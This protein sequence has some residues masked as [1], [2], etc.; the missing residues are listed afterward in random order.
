L[1]FFV[2]TSFGLYWQNENQRHLEKEHLYYLS[3][4]AQSESTAIERRV[5]S[6]FAATNFLAFE[7]KQNNGDFFDFESYAKEVINSIGGIS[8][9]Q[10]A[11]DGIVSKVYPI[12][13]NEVVIGH[14]LFVDDKRTKEAH[15]ARV[16]KKLTLAGPFETLQGSVAVIGRNPIFLTKDNEEVFWG[17]ASAMITVDDLLASTKFS[18]LDQSKYAYQLSRK[19]PDTQKEEVFARSTYNIVEPFVLKKINLPNA[20]WTLTI[21]SSS[22]VWSQQNNYFASIFLGVL[23]AF[24]IG[25]LFL[26]PEYL[27]KIVAEKTDELEKLA[28]HDQLTSLGNRRLLSQKLKEFLDEKTNPIA[29]LLYLDL[30][31][32]KRINDSLGHHSGDYLL[33]ELACRLVNIVKSNDIVAR[34][35]GDE[36]ALLIFDV[37]SKHSIENIAKRIIDEIKKP[38]IFGNNSLVVSASLG[39][40]L[41][42]KDGDNEEELLR[43]VDIAMYDAKNYGK[44]N[45]RFFDQNLQIE[46][47]EKHNIELALNHVFERDELFLHY[48]PLVCL[49]RNKI[50][51]YEVLLRWKHP[52]NGLIPP[53]KFIPVAENTGQIIPIGYWVFEQACKAIKNHMQQFNQ[54]LHVSVN[55]S[56][57]QFLD[58][59]LLEN[60][61]SVIKQQNI[62]PSCLEIEITESS[63]AVDIN[64]AIVI[65]SKLRSL[66]INIAIDD[67]GT[68]YS[69]LSQLRNLPVDRLKIDRNF[70][71]NLSANESDQ[72]IVKAIIAMAH[73]LKIN[74][75]AEGIETQEQ[76]DWLAKNNCDVGQGYFLARPAPLNDVL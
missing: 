62:E 5:Y 49:R 35:G 33:K 66:G 32:F 59:N 28:F 68:G 55:L 20:T 43:N 51:A 57:K 8:N 47:L 71:A 72:K 16:T 40:T 10:L 69:S 34:L 27:K 54:P 31:D 42:P 2:V 37:E 13:G 7:V 19:N 17:F 46:T 48:Q 76:L 25:Y 36:F 38:V 24:G 74:V 1:C 44:N 21:S 63:L 23:M 26:K 14:K 58:P 30:D 39:I 52:E 45:Y 61:S 53:D 56:A 6:A 4:I 18:E 11:P 9:L 75:V 22:T 70:I 15:I 41:I 64:N 67:F 3:E 65:L 12:V 29:A 73:A 50:L 60:L